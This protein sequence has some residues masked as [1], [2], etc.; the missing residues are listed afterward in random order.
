MSP[1]TLTANL[2]LMTKHPLVGGALG[3]STDIKLYIIGI[4]YVEL[5][6][7]DRFELLLILRRSNYIVACFLERI[8]M[9]NS[10]P[11]VFF[12]LMKKLHMNQDTDDAE[13]IKLNS[14]KKGLS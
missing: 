4:L 14:S 5:K 11:M 12:F 13:A 10:F 8:A 1:A 7:K 3:Q 6:I 2:F 9:S